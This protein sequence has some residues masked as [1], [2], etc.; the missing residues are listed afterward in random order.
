MKDKI[1]WR[2]VQIVLILAAAYGC[3]TDSSGWGW[4][5]FAFFLTL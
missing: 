3:Y 4:F 5:L 1:L 2:I